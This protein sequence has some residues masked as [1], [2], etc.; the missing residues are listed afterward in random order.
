MPAY[1]NRLDALCDRVLAL[2]STG[3]RAIVGIAGP[4][5][6]GKSRLAHDLVSAVD[7]IRVGWAAAV[8]MDGFHLADAQLARL[9]LT[10]RKGAPETF[11]VAGYAALLARLRADDGHDVYAPGFERDLEQ[12]I[13]ASIVVAAVARVVVTEGNYLLAPSGR[14]PEVRALL[15]E[16]WYVELDDATRVARLID[17]HVAFGK[18]AD[19][20]R[21]WVWRS[22]EANARF[23]QTTRQHA[24]LVVELRR[25]P[26]SEGVVGGSG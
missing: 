21:A 24:D 2:T 8:P 1:V 6:S 22:D 10:D 11:D 19:V 9:G 13:A 14:W 26:P 15:D 4:P 18:P 25:L 16:V 7:A 3:R 5:G 23:V 12:P 20:A 17:R